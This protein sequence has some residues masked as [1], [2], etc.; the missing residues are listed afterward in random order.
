[1]VNTFS[2]F[3]IEIRVFIIVQVRNVLLIVRL[4]YFLNSQK[5]GSFTCDAIT[6]FVSVVS[7]IKAGSVWVT[8]IIGNIIFAVVMVATVVE[9]RA[10][11]NSVV[12]V[13]YINNG[14]SVVSVIKC[15][16][17]CSI[18]LFI[19]ICLNASSL[20]IINII[21]AIAFIEFL[22]IFMICS[23]VRLLRRFSVKI[24][25]IMVINSVT[26]GLSI[27]LKKR[28]TVLVF[29]NVIL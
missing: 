16:I 13:Q 22:M 6:L 29:G 21:I 18:S 9:F 17:Q 24:V 1:M 27:N 15:E 3:I 5:L 10:I 28:R 12:I 23:M 2:K 11:R 25:I 19:N 26:V 8:L 20:A 14:E 4:K 7:I